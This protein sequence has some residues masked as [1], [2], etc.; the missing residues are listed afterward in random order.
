LAYL[1]YLDICSAQ[2]EANIL[3]T[4]ELPASG[5]AQPLVIP[6]NV[7]IIGTRLIFTGWPTAEGG[8]LDYKAGEG[9]SG[10]SEP[11]NIR[12]NNFMC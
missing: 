7:A 2:A 8:F 6:N 9:A 11:E 5:A 3:P 10:Q 12:R 1:K 4:S